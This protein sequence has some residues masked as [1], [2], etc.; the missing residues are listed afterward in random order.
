M[1]LSSI[2]EAP[3]LAKTDANYV[4]LSPVSILKRTAQVHPEKPAVIHGSIRRNWAETEQRCK[5][6]AS[7]LQKRG[8]GKGDTVSVLAP[9]IPELLECHFGIPMIGAVLNA[10]NTRL[11]AATIAYILDHSEAKILLV[12]TEL[13]ELAKE[14]LALATITPLIV[15]IDDAEGPSGPHIGSL[16]YEQLLSEGDDDYI[17]GPPSDEWDA[18]TVGYTSGT[19]GNPKGVVYSHRGAYLNAVNNTL[20]WAMPHFPVYLWTLPMFHCNG[21]CFPWSITLLAGCHVFLRKTEAGAIYDSFADHGVTHLCGAPIIMSLLASADET[22]KRPFMQKIEMMTAAA[23]PPPTVIKSIEAIGISITHVYG[24]TEVYGPAVICAWKP[25]WNDLPADEQ[26]RLKSRQGVAY[27]LQEACMV[28]D[29]K[30]GAAI[31]ADGHTMGEIA[32]RGNIVM[33]GYLKS[34]DETKKAFAD[35]WF[36]TGDLAVLHEDGYIEIRDRSKDIIISGGENISSI[37]IEKIL[38]AHDAVV[39]AAVVAQPDEKWGES[40]CAFIELISE[41]AASEAELDAYCQNKLAGFK[42]PKRFIFGPLPKTSTG[43]IR[44]N[45]LRILIKEGN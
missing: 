22:Q 36:W 18:I 12:D 16:T 8:I 38:F 33:K 35:G 39:A 4:P 37:E 45:E 14:A 40:P 42:R 20:C 2:Y 10:N 44:K 25:E 41:N 30:T 21:W 3:E 24:L 34:A 17:Y 13:S 5:Q 28:L 26:A 9:N 7:A 23:P 31:P 19:T 15:D 1:V 11:D 6:L 32:M 43:K 29:P 27:E